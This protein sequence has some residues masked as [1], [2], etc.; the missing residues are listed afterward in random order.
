MS[1]QDT[2][3]WYE[4]E[5]HRF[6]Y[7]LARREVDMVRAGKFDAKNGTETSNVDRGGTLVRGGGSK[8]TLIVAR[9]EIGGVSV[10]GSRQFSIHV[11]MLL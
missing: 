9:S 5:L 11:R 4:R 1:Y 6:R 8:S 2:Y 10:G 3:A 7:R